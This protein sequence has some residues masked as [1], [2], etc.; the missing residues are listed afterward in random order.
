MR[1]AVLLPLLV[2]FAACSNRV[3]SSDPW[4]ARTS[5]LDAPAL[6]PGLWVAL[7]PKAFRPKK[8][9]F[10]ESAPLNT[11]PDCVSAFIVEDGEILTP[12]VV[13]A[14]DKSRASRRYNWT[15]HPL[16]LAAG[17]PRINQLTHCDLMVKKKA[18]ENA[19]EANIE[20]NY[21]Y[22]AVRPVRLDATG[23]ITATESWPILCGPWPKSQA[24]DRAS[25]NVTDAPFPGLHVVGDN[26]IASS[27]NALRN[28]ARMSEVL[29]LSSGLGPGEAHWVRAAHR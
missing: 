8:C 24:Q 7:Q 19:R 16:V 22:E 2:L 15:R 13:A 26:C 21:C 14:K 20:V 3:V 5:E 27:E 1:C 4:F 23:R 17:E 29:A 9:R 28:A 25:A 11:W 18:D 12:D 10:R 6:R